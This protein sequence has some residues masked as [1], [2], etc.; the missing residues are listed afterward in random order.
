MRIPN[1]V[2]FR[3]KEKLALAAMQGNNVFENE[4]NKLC[5]LKVYR[6]HKVTVT[7]IFRNYWLDF[8]K[9]YPGEIRPSIIKTVDAL[10]GCKDFSKGHLFYECCKCQYQ[11]RSLYW[12]ETRSVLIT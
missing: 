1:D 9:A 2:N 4:F 6:L 10:I 11:T 8:L 12:C 7:D 3:F 5:N